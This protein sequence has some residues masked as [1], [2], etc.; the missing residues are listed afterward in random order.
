M[1][2]L[3]ILLFFQA[4]TLMAQEYEQNKEYIASLRSRVIEDHI[5]DSETYKQCY[6]KLSD[7]NTDPETLKTEVRNCVSNEIANA[8]KEDLEKLQ[9]SL[10]IKDIEISGAKTSDN[11]QAYLQERIHDAIH[12][13]GSYNKKKLKELKYVDQKQYFYLYR[14]QIHKNITLDLAKY[15]LENVGSSQGPE[16]FVNF[17]MDSGNL[18]KEDFGSNKFLKTDTAKYEQYQLATYNSN[19]DKYDPKDFNAITASA[20]LSTSGNDFGQKFKEYNFCPSINHGSTPEDLKDPCHRTHARGPELI[21][22]LKKYEL[23]QSKTKPDDLAQRFLVCSRVVLQNA[24]EVY[25]CNNTYDW[26][27]FDPSKEDTI[28]KKLKYCKNNLGIDLTSS[29]NNQTD[30]NGNTIVS[31]DDIAKKNGQHACNLISKIEGYKKTLKQVDAVLADLDENFKVRHGYAVESTFKGEYRGG[32]G[33]DE[34]KIDEMTTVASKELSTK[35][36]QF[37][38]NKEAAQELRQ[39]CMDENGQVINLTDPDCQGLAMNPDQVKSMRAATLQAEAETQAYLKRIEELKGNDEDLKTFLAKH[40]LESYIGQVGALPDEEIIE[41][42]KTKYKADRQ[43]VISTMND[44]LYDIINKQDE[45]EI[46]QEVANEKI[47]EIDSKKERLETLFNY[48]NIVTSYVQLEAEDGSG[49]SSNAMA[50]N[51]EA[52]GFDEYAEDTEEV[53]QYESFFDRQDDSSDSGNEDRFYSTETLINGIG[54]FATAD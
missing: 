2:L 24:C 10:E 49:A 16:Y 20:L 29:A 5:I 50:R 26:K 11:L 8:S 28:N 1:K 27:K 47:A 21:D 52:Q 6:D 40:G 54:D 9:S 33:D 23:E 14:S 22:Q 48:A 15:C 25:R 53:K 42:L 31:V 43:A 4:L 7:T 35:V 45:S 46:T 34:K 39:K 36:E 12:G 13:P 18:S 30:I 19:E 38:K 17:K 37:S 51:I 41:V 32:R 3:S 44:K